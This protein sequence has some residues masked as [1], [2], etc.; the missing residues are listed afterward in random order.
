MAQILVTSNVLRTKATE[1]QKVSTD[2]TNLY[3]EMLQ[4]VTSTANRMQGTAVE[5]Q[6]KEFEQMRS[7]FKIFNDDLAKYSK[8]LTN[9][10]GEYEQVE[11][12]GTENARQ[13]TP[14]L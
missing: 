1:I 9:A 7:V 2:V 12:R 5:T 4:I 3:N 8:F 11:N 13:I 10:A 6:K 14:Q